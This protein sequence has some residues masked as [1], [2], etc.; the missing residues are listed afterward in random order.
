M[1]V[2]IKVP[3]LQGSSNSM[4]VLPCPCSCV[5]A[6]A[7]RSGRRP[8]EW[9]LQPQHSMCRACSASRYHLC[10]GFMFVYL[11][12]FAYSSQLASNCSI[13]PPSIP[14]SAYAFESMRLCL[15]ALNCVVRQVCLITFNAKV[16][17]HGDGVAAC[18]VIQGKRHA[19]RVWHSI[20]NTFGWTPLQA[21]SW[22]TLKVFCAQVRFCPSS[23]LSQSNHRAPACL[24]PCVI[25]IRF[26]HVT[27]SSTTM[28]ACRLAEW[29]EEVL[30]HWGQRL[31]WPWV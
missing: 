25:C 21:R 27:V 13:S 18:T 10:F 19:M 23:P 1:N 6:H 2:T 7:Q 15:I 12:R 9:L 14:T 22:M 11:N 4:S 20:C 16:S 8:K 31:L 3:P 5:S 28:R 29:R 24:P 17:V 26:N 30:L